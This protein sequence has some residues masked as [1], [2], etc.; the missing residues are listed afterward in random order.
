[1]ENQVLKFSLDTSKIHIND[2]I[3]KLDVKDKSALIMI[4]TKLEAGLLLMS[5]TYGRYFQSIFPFMV[6]ARE[7]FEEDEKMAKICRKKFSSM[8]RTYVRTDREAAKEQPSVY[9]L[10]TEN[11]DIVLPKKVKQ[12]E[13]HVVVSLS[14]IDSRMQSIMDRI[15]SLYMYPI[16]TCENSLEFDVTTDDVINITYAINATLEDVGK[17]FLDANSNDYIDSLIEE[18]TKKLTEY[19]VATSRPLKKLYNLIINE[20]NYL[21]ILYRLICRINNEIGESVELSAPINMEDTGKS[22]EELYSDFCEMNEKAAKNDPQVTGFNPIPKKKRKSFFDF[23]DTGW[24]NGVS[25]NIAEEE[26][27]DDEE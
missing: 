7:K 15:V 9:S 4:T 13:T 16:D 10:K 20:I 25:N 5:S 1:M 6:V 27:E 2:F 14:D 18:V 22:F 17:A 19:Y 23:F 26:I 24:A 12:L 11:Y 21:T 8:T 3:R